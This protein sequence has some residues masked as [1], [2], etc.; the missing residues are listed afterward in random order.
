[1]SVRAALCL[2][3]LLFWCGCA[4]RPNAGAPKS[5]EPPYPVLMTE[6]AE[7]REAA[8][9]AWTRFTTEQGITNAPRPELQPVTATLRGL[10]TLTG[11]PVYLP[12]V[13]QGATMTE[14]DTRESLRRFITSISDLIGAQPQQLSLVQRA[15]LADGTKKARYEQRP[16]RFPLRG[17]YGV[18]EI[19]F[20]PDR[21]VLQI[22]S[23]C[24]P[25]IEQLQRAGAGIRAKLNPDQVPAQIAGKTFTY[26][27][28]AGNRQTFTVSKGDAV[29]VRELVVYPT[30]RAA[31]ASVLEFHLAWEITVGPAS[32]QRT[33]YLDAVT[34]EIITAT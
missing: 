19:T 6:T 16:F 5:N 33:I 21:R 14:E 27:D 9:A 32:N 29:T 4:N 12:K 2:L 10:P 1:M 20:A 28:A 11:T 15:D 17:G 31:D 18:L 7:R 8:L 24:I 26:T 34:N 3:S 30:P 23:T 25:E 22:T 13:G